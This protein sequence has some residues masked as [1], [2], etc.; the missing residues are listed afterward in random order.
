VEGISAEIDD[1]SVTLMVVCPGGM[2]TNFQS[3]AGVK[4]LGGEKLAD[5]NDVADAVL[6]SVGSGK[7]TLVLSARSKA[8]AL[9]ARVIP[10]RWSVILW[11]RLMGKMR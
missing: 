5:P 3:S 9:L 6:K 2:S 11:K 8:M 4:V 7:T 10:R 1:P